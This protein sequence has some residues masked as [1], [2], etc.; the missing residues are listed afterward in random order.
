MTKKIYLTGALLFFVSVILFSGNVF[1]TPTLGVATD[2]GIYA[3]TDPMALTDEYIDYFADSIVPAMG[4]YEGFVVGPNGSYLTVFTSYV[5][6][7]TSIYLLINNDFN[8]LPITFGGQSLGNMGDTGQANGY[9]PLPYYGVLLPSDLS[10]WT[11]AVFEESKTFYL[12]K[13]QLNYSGD[14]AD[15]CYFFAGADTD[16]TSGLQ[17]KGGT[18]D[19]FSPKTTSAGGHTPEPATMSLLGLGILGLAGFRK[20]W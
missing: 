2:T 7:S 13:A 18:P 12:Y 3:Y 14:I 17:F 1:A 16:G 10:V 5:P 15:N 11:T 4:E 19:D 9:K 8:N 20:R 6:S